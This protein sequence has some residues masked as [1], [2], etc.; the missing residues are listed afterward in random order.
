[1]PPSRAQAFAAID[2]TPAA[3]GDPPQTGPVGAAKLDEVANLAGAT[4]GDKPEPQ[5][6]LVRLDHPLPPIRPIELAAAASVAAAAAPSQ[7]ARAAAS[8]GNT[9]IGTT[10]NG[11]DKTSLEALF[12]TSALIPAHR[13]SATPVKVANSVVH[14]ALPKAAQDIIAQPSSSAGHFQVT[15]TPAVVNHFSGKAVQ[16]PNMLG[17]TATE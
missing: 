6:Q 1:M 3:A 16:S 11:H 13:Q 8:G 15:A 7:T 12:D 17:F 5:P 9:T 4:T 10:L 2:P 14:A